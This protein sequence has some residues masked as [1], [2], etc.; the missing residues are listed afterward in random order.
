[1]AGNCRWQPGQHLLRRHLVQRRVNH[2]A[3]VGTVRHTDISSIHRTKE[4][5]PAMMAT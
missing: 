4:I 3:V 1:M 5:H 2:A